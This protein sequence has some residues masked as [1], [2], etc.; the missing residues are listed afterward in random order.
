MVTDRHSASVDDEAY[1]Y[2]LTMARLEAELAEII[3]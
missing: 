2:H 1:E 3:K